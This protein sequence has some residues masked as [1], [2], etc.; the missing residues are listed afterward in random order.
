MPFVHSFEIESPLSIAPITVT[1]DYEW[2]PPSCPQ[3]KVFGHSCKA[4]PPTPLVADIG[5]LPTTLPVTSANIQ[6]TT[7]SK[8][9]L[10][11]PTPAPPQPTP[12]TEQP[13]LAASPSN[14]DPTIIPT[15]SPQLPPQPMQ[16]QSPPSHTKLLQQPNTEPLA[17]TN[18]EDCNSSQESGNEP[19]DIQ[20][21]HLSTLHANI[22]LES[23][24]DSLRSTSE[25]SFA[26]KEISDVASTSFTNADPVQS[27]V[28][29]PTTTKKKKGGRK[30]K[31]ARGH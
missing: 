3:C 9:P 18:M 24:M 14:I 23:K 22:C 10:P 1:V 11:T 15:Y 19:L 5:N 27:P 25:S 20:H 13:H 21:H 17:P 12:I 30:K 2:K 31:E 28:P 7:A 16:T 6:D 8:T 26:G 4:K 29:S